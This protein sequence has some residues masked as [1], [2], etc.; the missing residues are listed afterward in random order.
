MPKRNGKRGNGKHGNG[1]SGSN[2]SDGSG[3]RKRAR[4]AKARMTR[5]ATRVRTQPTPAPRGTLIVIGGHED[6]EEEK[7]ILR[8]VAARAGSGRLVVATV[9][10]EKP[11]QLWETYERVFRGLGVRHVYHLDVDSREEAKTEQKLRVLDDATVVFFTGGDQLRITSQLGDTP[12]YDRLREIYENGGTIAGTSAGASV[13]CET[14][15]VS[16]GQ[17]GSSAIASDL[18]MAPGFGLFPGVIIDQHFAERGRITRLVAAVTQ[19]PR[20]LGIGIDENTAVV[21]DRHRL[22]VLG[23]GA[24]YVLDAQDLSYTNLTE[25]AGNRTIS[26]YHLRLHLLSMGD[27]FDLVSR[28]PSNHPAEEVEEEL[29]GAD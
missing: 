7:L 18:R 4:A 9:A 20:I 15:L 19:N 21:R 2:G 25:E 12:I 28:E 27:E 10:S 13:V 24:V 5:S 3:T 26:A 17:G 6:K 11:Q 16:G 22:R 1:T 14:M 29:V 23:A 8:A